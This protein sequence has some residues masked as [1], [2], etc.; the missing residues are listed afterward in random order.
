MTTENFEQSFVSCQ[1]AT[2]EFEKRIL[3]HLKEKFQFGSEEEG[4]FRYVGMQVKQGLDGILVDQNHYL[5]TVEI[6]EIDPDKPDDEMLDDDGQSDFRGIVGKIGWLGGVSRPDLAY[7]HVVM[8]TK[9]GKATAVDMKQAIKVIKKLKVEQVQ[10]MF[11]D[12]GNIRE[13]KFLATVMLDLEV[14][15]TKLQA[16]GDRL[17]LLRTEEQGLLVW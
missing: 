11:P 5:D 3:Q 15:L 6:P 8:S 1:Q 13:W 7:D 2:E 4:E 9:L 17:L 10:M 12:L 14:F 16:V